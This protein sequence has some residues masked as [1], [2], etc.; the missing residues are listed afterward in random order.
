MKYYISLLVAVAAMFTLFAIFALPS[1]AQT[2]SEVCE[3]LFSKEDPVSYVEAVER[4]AVQEAFVAG[5]IDLPHVPLLL[6]CLDRD[7][8][9][10][11]EQMRASCQNDAPLSVDE[12]TQERFIRCFATLPQEIEP[13][14]QDGYD[15]EDEDGRSGSECSREV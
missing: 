2:Q 3:D 5:N 6:M 13:G 4:Y 11:V 14:F 9:A 1:P 8:A 10:Y 12:L 7:R 15:G